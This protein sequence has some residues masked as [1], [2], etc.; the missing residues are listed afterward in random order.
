MTERR[1]RRADGESGTIL[2][3]AA[4]IGSLLFTLL[5]SVISYALINIGDDAGVNAAR[6]GARRAVLYW[7]DADDTTSDN[8]KTIYDAVQSKL[9]GL[10][11]E[12]PTVD[13]SC[14]ASTGGQLDS[15]APEAVTA[16][17]LPQIQVT[18]TWNRAT[19]S[20][21]MSNTQK[22]DSARMAIVGTPPDG[23]TTP[24]VG[25][26][27]SITASVSPASANLHDGS[28]DA[29]P[30]VTA[31]VSDVSNCG[32]PVISAIDTPAGYEDGV[33]PLSMRQDGT[34]RTFTYTLLAG[35]TD[36]S[37]AWSAG[38]KTI[39][40]ADAH[41]TEQATTSFEVDEAVKPGAISSASYTDIDH[42]GRIDS[43]ALLFNQ[44]VVPC[45]NFYVNAGRFDISGLP[46]GV[47]PVWVTTNGGGSVTIYLWGG[48][49]D[50]GPQG[51]KIALQ[52]S[53]DGLCT[54]GGD[55]IGFDT[56][57]VSDGAKPVLLDIATTNDGR[58]AGKPERGDT[59][60]L[61]FSEPID[62]SSLPSGRRTMT[63]KHGSGSKPPD[64]FSIDGLGGPWSLGGT[65]LSY[66]TSKKLTVPVTLS[67]DGNVVRI[68]VADDCSCG[69]W[70]TGGPG[71]ITFTAPSTLTDAALNSATGSVTKS[72]FRFL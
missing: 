11:A 23:T 51:V 58:I 12:A 70:S 36:G 44:A 6:E 33:A 26:S 55:P 9:A 10:L 64:V 2:I 16:V 8:Y 27:C 66:G 39:K 52:P 67:V 1:A 31:V 19:T 50:T 28:L 56:T 63:I 38:T 20:P 15:C 69:S 42:D 34:S 72:W 46:W 22:T 65:Y 29:A 40:V 24:P 14:W 17:D 43:I 62:L 21:F 37:W 18:V 25:G 41:G 57:A 54:T 53:S 47:F 59:F 45:N 35:A 49:V 5:L 60:E 71:T 3:E 4:L 48:T 32:A 13:V 30:V 61:T 68:T 7:Q